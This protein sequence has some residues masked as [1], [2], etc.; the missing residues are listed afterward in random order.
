MKSVSATFTG[1]ASTGKAAH[2]LYETDTDLA[3]A[4]HLTAAEVEAAE[5]CGAFGGLLSL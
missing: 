1:S 4:L 5:R 2:K 3:L